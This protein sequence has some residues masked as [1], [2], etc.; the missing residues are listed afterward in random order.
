MMRKS[1]GAVAVA[2]AAG[3][4]MAAGCGGGSGSDGSVAGTRVTVMAPA[5]LKGALEAA[6]TA[7][8]TGH[9]G[10]T[11]ILN[12]GHVPALLAQL[13]EGVPADVI[14]APD[15]AT[16]RQVQSKGLVGPTS[17]AVARN[18]LVLVCPAQTPAGAR[19]VTSLG[20]GKLTIAVC[21]AEL[22]CGKLARRLAEKAGVALA[23]DSQEPGGSPAVVTKVAAG[24]V[25]LGVAFATDVG[26]ANGK[27]KA[28]RLDD[29]PEASVTVM[30][31][32][33][34][35]PA[36]AEAADQFLAFLSSAEG[37]ASFTEAGFSPP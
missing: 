23:A 5:P 27:A 6:K 34:K 30:A 31:A 7:F 26:A 17:V 4:A 14:V 13:S 25:D 22:P 11:V 12:F 16:M 19:D 9:P 36:A 3:L 21:A 15:E 18:Q 33:L 8:E 20:D 2:V 37:R 32:E 24:E 1:S 28:F 29:A 10:S 35:A